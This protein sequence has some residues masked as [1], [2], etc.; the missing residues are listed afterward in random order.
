MIRQLRLTVLLC[1]LNGFPHI[2]IGATAI[3]GA[4]RDTTIYQS[5]VNNSAGGGA[6]IFIGSNGQ[7]SP[8]RGLIDFDI[9]GAVPAGATITAANL[10]M[11]L[12]LAAN[13]AN[14]TIGL[15]RMNADWGEGTAGSTS[16]PVSGGGS[17]FAAGPGDATWNARFHSATTPTLWS[18]PGATGDFNSMA[19]A[20]TTVGGS[21]TLESPYSWTST[22]SLV[23]DV[24]SWLDSPLT[25]FGWAVVSANE[26]SNQ[27]VRAFY[28]S[29]ATQNSSGG[30][31]DPAWRPMLTVTYVVPE[32]A[33]AGLI[34]IVG[35]L[36]LFRRRR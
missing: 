10:R 5:A 36:A 2:A 29:E 24:Q 15:H 27:S 4:G 14:V 30:T 8:R 9:T 34:A 35:Q 17:G 1:A 26:S 18:V 13:N 32:P 7:G 6:G 21:G 23:S 12:G 31:L 16:I 19:S 20:T 25:N 33:T 11:V 28:S 3:I 22:P